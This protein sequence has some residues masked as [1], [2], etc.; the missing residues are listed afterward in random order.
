MLL[1]DQFYFLSSFAGFFVGKKVEEKMPAA[2][3]LLP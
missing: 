1:A 2:E 3:A